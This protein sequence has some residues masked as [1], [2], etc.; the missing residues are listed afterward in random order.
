[1]TD[2][3]QTWRMNG[4]T[5]F[6]LKFVKSSK[7]IFTISETCCY[8]YPLARGAFS[9]CFISRIAILPLEGFERSSFDVRWERKSGKVPE[10]VLRAHPASALGDRAALRAAEHAGMCAVSFLLKPEDNNKCDNNIIC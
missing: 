5:T 1:M 8:R 3:K 4:L 9:L 6:S 2:V 10:R 7:V